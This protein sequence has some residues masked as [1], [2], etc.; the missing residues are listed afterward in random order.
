ME[1]KKTVIKKLAYAAMCVAL[2]MVLPFLTGQIPEIGKSLQPMHIAVLLAGFVCGWQYGAVVGLVSPLLRSLIF[3]TP[4]LY[5][6]AIV[7][8][9][10]LAA[11]GLLAGLLYKLLPKKTGYIYVSLIGA[12]LGGRLVWGITKYIVLGIKGTAF[13]MSAFIAGG[14]VNALPGIILQIVLVP[15]IVMGLKKAKLMLNE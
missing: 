8:T 5:P 9:F 13:P 7:M 14:F 6:D 11:Y 1:K 15:L 12:M 4:K 3:S 2:A 10:E